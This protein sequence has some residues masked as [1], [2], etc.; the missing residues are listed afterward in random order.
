MLFPVQ[1]RPYDHSFY[2]SVMENHLGVSDCAKLVDL[3][4]ALK[5]KVKV[6][7]KAKKR[8][9]AMFSASSIRFS[10]QLLKR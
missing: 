5:V 8:Q 7:L 3:G 9:M 2:V 6:K 4:W 1:D 10:Y